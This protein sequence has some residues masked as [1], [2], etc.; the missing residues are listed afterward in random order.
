M[1]F[2]LP[3]HQRIPRRRKLGEFAG[4]AAGVGM[5]ALGG[6]LVALLDF[7][8]RRLPFRGK[9]EQPAVLRF[10]RQHRRALP[11]AGRVERV[12]RAA[13][14]AEAPPR[15]VAA[16]LVRCL[17]GRAAQAR[18]R[19]RRRLPQYLICPVTRDL[20]GKRSGLANVERRCRPQPVGV[21]L[22]LFLLQFHDGITREQSFAFRIPQ[23]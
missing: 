6:A 13:D 2:S 20:G 21:A 23:F 3:L 12:Q 8:I 17:Q 10:A 11:E 22:P 7:R 14:G 18:Q 9:S 15:H 1:I 4:A 16:H 5:Q 19:L